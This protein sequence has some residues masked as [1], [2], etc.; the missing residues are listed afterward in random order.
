MDENADY[1]LAVSKPDEGGRVTVTSATFPGLSVI[2]HE[3]EVFDWVL[4]E[5]DKIRD[6]ASSGRP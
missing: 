6:R 3:E 4:D 2:G 1:V 5:I